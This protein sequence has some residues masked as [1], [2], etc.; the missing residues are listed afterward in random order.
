MGRLIRLPMQR[1]SA[2]Q[3]PTPP[4]AVIVSASVGAGHDAVAE[5]L[6]AR[7]EE[8][9]VV[10]DRHDFLDLLP[11]PA[12]RVLVGSYHKMLERAPWTWKLLYG[13][14]DNERMMS[15]QASLFTALAG[16]RMRAVVSA[17]DT[18]IVVS[19]YPLASQV[20]GRLRRRGQVRTPVHTY[21]TDFS[22]H[23]LWASPD[24]DA[25]LA[26]NPVPAAQAREVGCSGVSVVAPLVDR[27]FTPVTPR[28]RYA[29]RARWSL[30]QEA[31]LALLVGGSWGA[32]E[33]E[34]T[35]ADIEA[36][37]PGITCL[38]VCGRNESL[39]ERLLAAGVR[40]AYGWVSD[41]PS[42]MHAA[43][44]LVQ[45]AGGMTV[46]EAVASG[47]PVVTYRSIPGHGLTNAAALDEAGVARWVKQ[48][49][50][51]AEALADAV[52]GGSTRARAAALPG[53]DA[54]R[55]LLDSAGL[56]H[57]ATHQVPVPAVAVA[58][59]VPVVE[60]ESVR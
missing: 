15:M 37:D 47:L 10:V 16:R 14:M 1:R 42:L 50:E 13:G 51:L 29:A 20:L 12:G 58:G 59:P 22:V 19:T 8:A 27:R 11:G 55:T 32:G 49:G 2:T 35:V 9:G 4:R 3:L 43:D 46:Q 45:N 39:R 54:V 26:V 33:I 40:H 60:M 23:R 56:G 34:R 21:L 31:R 25:H 18:R 44:V 38:V 52:Y 5:E 48:P 7:L 28:A 53:A 36:A 6:A 17:D 41:M 30:P 24:V 57:L